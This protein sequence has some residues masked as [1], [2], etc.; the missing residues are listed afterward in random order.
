MSQIKSADAVVIGGGARGCSIALFLARAGVRVALL[1]RRFISSMVSSANG[2]QVNVSCKLPEH[3][4]AM[5]LRSARMYPEFLDSLD[6]DIFL[7]QEGILFAALEPQEMA[8]LRQ[9]VEAVNRVPG[10]DAQLLDGREAREII[11]AL[12]SEVIGG[13]ITRAD[14]IVDVLKL[15]PAMARAAVR[16]GAEILRGVEVT[17]I[18]VEGGRVAGVNTTQGEIATPVVVNAAGVHVPHIGRMVGINI[19]VDADTATS[20]FRRPIRPCSLFPANM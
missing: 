3:Y 17:A 20:S 19:P 14:G 16:A 15:V 11:P 5:S 7:Q 13:Y 18:K 12:S 4:T 8:E 6:S 10:V 2:A 1:E 9:R